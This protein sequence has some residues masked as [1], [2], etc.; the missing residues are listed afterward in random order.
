M[1]PHLEQLPVGTKTFRENSS[2][3]DAA[4]DIAGLGST[5]ASATSCRLDKLYHSNMRRLRAKAAKNVIYR[6]GLKV[7]SRPMPADAFLCHLPSLSY[8]LRVARRWLRGVLTISPRKA[9]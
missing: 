3:R 7:G 2:E 1:D 9:P 4:G 5:K 8:V 6:P